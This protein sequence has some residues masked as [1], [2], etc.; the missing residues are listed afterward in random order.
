M[1]F[2]FFCL[3]A[4]YNKRKQTEYLEVLVAEN[5]IKKTTLFAAKLAFQ[6]D[7]QQCLNKFRVQLKKVWPL[8]QLEPLIH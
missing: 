4:Q 3:W 1:I 5:T 8:F 7:S 2:A 6:Y